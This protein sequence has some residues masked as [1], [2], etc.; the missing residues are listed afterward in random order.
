MRF[1]RC[2]SF[3]TIKIKMIRFASAKEKI[4]TLSDFHEACTVNGFRVPK[5]S[6]R[7]CTREFLQ[8]VRAGLVYVPKYGEMR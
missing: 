7:L 8:E 2:S 4:L 5:L 6:S 3:M 1:F